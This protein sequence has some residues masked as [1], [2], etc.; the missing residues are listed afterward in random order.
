MESGNGKMRVPYGQAVYG[1][2]EIDA[3]VKVLRSSLQMG[4][5][6]LEFERK[7]T[8]LFGK[9]SGVMV[10]SGS[11]AN[12]LAAELLG[13]EPG[14]EVITPVLTFPTTVSPL[15]KNGL[16]PAFV[17]VE[18]DT[19]NIDAS[20]IESM[21]TRNTRAM[22]IPN[23]LGNLPD[24]SGIREAADRC[25]LTVIEDSADT[26]GAEINRETASRFSDVSTASFY[27]SHVITCA[28]G[29]GMVCL[30]D[31]NLA[32][33]ARLLRSWGRSSSLLDNPENIED[34]L[35]VEIDGIPYD[36][37][38]TFEVQG[39]NFEPSEI[40]A[41][42]GLVQLKKL[43]HNI[44]TRERHFRAH[45]EFLR[46]YEEWFI[47]PRQFPG[48]RTGWLAFP[49]TIQDSAPFSRKELQVFLE[50]RGI[51]TRTVLT[52]NV[53]R[54]PAFKNIACKTAPGGYPNADLV[55]RGG[56]LI[57]CHHGL[58]DEQVAYTHGVLEE[59]AKNN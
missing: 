34:R 13:L 46:R 5:H 50:E 32:D 40:G 53:L 12:M 26:L 8:A 49:I 54:Q 25:G 51:Q 36:R 19:Y 27:G 2:E 7:I 33:R 9:K 56:I 42:F 47:L 6:V 4:N 35:S 44:E 17:D 37:K 57:G 45:T 21:I 43:N 31:K 30:N 52:G 48:S 23:L 18:E 10:N 55:T 39:Y 41:A 58:S 3:M 24:W 11:S 15:I 29:G 14:S 22:V 16:V 20:R 28:G 38:F 1:E 59:F